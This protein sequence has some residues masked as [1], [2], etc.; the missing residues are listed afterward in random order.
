MNV[1][2]D[3]QTPRL[4]GRH[5]CR[6]HQC[7]RVAQARE[8]HAGREAAATGPACAPRDEHRP[9]PCPPGGAP[10]PQ[11]TSDPVGLSRVT[12]KPQNTSSDPGKKGAKHPRRWW[13]SQALS[14]YLHNQRNPRYTIQIT[15]HTAS[16]RPGL[17][18][19]PF[20]TNLHRCCKGEVQ[21]CESRLPA[22][23]AQQLGAPA[24][25][26]PRA[27]FDRPWSLTMMA[28]WVSGRGRERHRGRCN[29]LPAPTH[30]VV[31]RRTAAAG[32]K[33]R[34]SH[35]RTQAT[36]SP[37]QRRSWRP[38][39]R[40]TPKTVQGGRPDRQQHRARGRAPVPAA[41]LIVLQPVLRRQLGA[42]CR[43]GSGRH[44]STT[45]QTSRI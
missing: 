40:R 39:S 36:Q 11:C 38:Q 3:T 27:A 32:R 14:L 26:P 15:R 22:A 17:H 44:E 23:P 10:S 28:W 42:S 30:A 19:S 5:S 45:Q 4:R 7:A 29:L 35:P 31:P 33:A 2:S 9:R 13:A 1:R 6:W 20:P 16:P 41:H 24:A 18:T 25:S 8:V 21:D 12:R 43:R 34:A 37:P